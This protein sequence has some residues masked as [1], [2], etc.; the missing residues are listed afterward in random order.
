MTVRTRLRQALTKNAQPGPR[1]AETTSV[2]R[3]RERR[4]P[5]LSDHPRGAVAAPDRRLFVPGAGEDLLTERGTTSQARRTAG[6]GHF[7]LPPEAGAAALRRGREGRAGASVIFFQSSPRRRCQ[8]RAEFRET[9]RSA[10][11]SSGAHGTRTARSRAL[12]AV[13]R[14]VRTPTQRARSQRA[15]QTGCMRGP[16]ARRGERVVSPQEE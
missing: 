9:A 12:V 1:R 3:R 6:A 10:R 8:R 2:L 11:S 5:R 7:R 16:R 14:L 4:R 15:A 13:R